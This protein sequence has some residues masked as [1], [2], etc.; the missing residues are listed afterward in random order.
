VHINREA[1]F[2]RRSLTGA[3]FVVRRPSFERILRL[4]NEGMT[5]GVFVARTRVGPKTARGE[6]CRFCDF[7]TVCSPRVGWQE[8]N[9]A[10]APVLKTLNDLR[11]IE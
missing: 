6:N 5:N 7:R 1:G 2:G 10:G 8:D 3:S 9:K 11:S 4:I